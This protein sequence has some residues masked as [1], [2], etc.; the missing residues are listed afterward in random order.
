[1][2]LRLNENPCTIGKN[3][4]EMWNSFDIIEVINNIDKYK[5]YK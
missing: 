1:M 2:F 5:I 4:F 3:T